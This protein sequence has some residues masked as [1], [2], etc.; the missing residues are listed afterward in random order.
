MGRYAIVGAAFPRYG[1]DTDSMRII[2]RTS[3][4]RLSSCL[5]ISDINHIGIRALASEASKSKW[6]MP[7]RTHR[8]TQ[9]TEGMLRRNAHHERIDVAFQDPRKLYL[10]CFPDEPYPSSWLLLFTCNQSAL[11]LSTPAMSQPLLAA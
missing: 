11:E 9:R 3:Q 5:I 4:G 7:L 10:I 2:D 8:T 6:I 1:S